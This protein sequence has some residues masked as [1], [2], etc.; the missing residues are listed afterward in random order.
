M[1][2]VELIAKLKAALRPPAGKENR[3]A[4]AVPIVVVES[5]HL[6]HF[7]PTLKTAYDTAER[8]YRYPLNRN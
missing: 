5:K 1:N 3:I 8:I 2:K 7:L 6:K 4:I